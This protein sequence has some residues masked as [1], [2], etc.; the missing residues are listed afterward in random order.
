MMAAPVLTV[1]CTNCGREM[2]K[3]RRVHRGKRFCSTCYPKVFERRRCLVCK[4]FACLPRSDQ[5]AVCKSCETGVP[6]IR[7]GKSCYRIG[8]ITF[9]GPV[10]NSCSVY[11]RP[12]RLAAGAS[13][14]NT[15]S[16]KKLRDTPIKISRIYA[17]C[18]ACRRYRIVASNICNIPLCKACSENDPVPCNV[19]G[20]EMPA[21]R[22]KRCEEC[23]WEDTFYHRVK[24]DV[25]GLSTQAVASL[26]Q[27]F[28][29]WLISEVSAQKAALSIHRYFLFFYEVDERWGG[30]PKYEKLVNHFGA[31]GLRRVCLPMR[32]LTETYRVII[33]VTVREAISE[34]RRIE[35]TMSLL[36]SGTLQAK[37]LSAYRDA[38]FDRIAAG[39]AT[40]KSVR[41]SLRPAATLLVQCDANGVSIPDQ[42]SLTRYLIQVPGQRAAITGF[43]NFININYNARVSIEVDEKTAMAAYKKRLEVDL[44]T[45]LGEK[46]RIDPLFQRRWLSLALA[47]FHGLPLSVGRKISG[48]QICIQDDGSFLVCWKEAHYWLPNWRVSHQHE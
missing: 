46:Q 28:G 9:Y 14:I 8:K 40:L 43:V 3:A 4:Q 24:L 45:L 47:Y 5:S 18:R 31:E 6:C 35:T 48:T 23:Y 29:R 25:A 7:C 13:P 1:C 33:D 26:F 20:R 21:G 27:E 34:Q 41:L 19:C 32:W 17:T 30:I 11:F 22:G 42:L 39:R 12:A 36:G 2:L 44:I 16:S 37:I 10:C 38:M 15:I